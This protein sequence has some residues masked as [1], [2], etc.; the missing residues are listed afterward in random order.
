M[1]CVE[2]FLCYL[3]T[4]LRISEKLFRRFYV[5]V[6]ER[7]C[8]EREQFPLPSKPKCKGHEEEDFEKV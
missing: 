8:S 6:V 7:P 1:K 2:K 4:F 5:I 3:G